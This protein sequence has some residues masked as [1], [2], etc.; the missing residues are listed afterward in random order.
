MF[1]KILD[2]V[3]DKKNWQEKWKKIKDFV[4]KKGIKGQS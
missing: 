1:K 4:K 3:L 2:D